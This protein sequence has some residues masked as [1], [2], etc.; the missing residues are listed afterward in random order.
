MRSI[1]V[2]FGSL[3]LIAAAGVAESAPRKP[4]KRP[5]AAI[6]ISNQRQMGLEQFELSISGED[7]KPVARLA[8]PLAAGKKTRIVLKGA[9]GCDYIARWKFEDAGDEAQVD[10]CNDPKIVLTD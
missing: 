5:P 7:G 3:S 2:C 9:K 8:K 6:E 1:W 4:A 10:L